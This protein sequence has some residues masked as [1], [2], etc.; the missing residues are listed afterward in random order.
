MKAKLGIFLII[1]AAVTYFSGHA[2]NDD[3][4][5]LV[6]Q[7]GFFATGEIITPKKSKHDLEVLAERLIPK[8][9][10]IQE[11]NQREQEFKQELKTLKDLQSEINSSYIQ[12]ASSSL[13]H[14][15]E[16]QKNLVISKHTALMK[17]AQTTVIQKENI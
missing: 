16:K 3:S 10:S 17:A 11:F 2:K 12:G 1:I 8:E 13:L 15:Y 7:Q 6:P 4:K 14:Q 5:K 9:I